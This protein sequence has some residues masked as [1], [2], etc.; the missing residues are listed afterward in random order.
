MSEIIFPRDLACF[1]EILRLKFGKFYQN[2]SLRFYKFLRRLAK[3]FETF[4]KGSKKVLKLFKKEGFKMVLK[5]F[6]GL[7]STPACLRGRARPEGDG[8]PPHPNCRPGR[9]RRSE[10]MPW[11]GTSAGLWCWFSALGFFSRV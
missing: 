7:K 9:W 11:R 2:E 3:K 6:K 5:V 1:S 4:L 8:D 10:R